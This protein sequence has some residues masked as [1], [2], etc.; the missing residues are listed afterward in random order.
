[1]THQALT[2]SRDR[3]RYERS[4]LPRKD[5]A[6]HCKTQ[7]GFTV[8]ELIVAMAIAAIM[9]GVALPAFMSFVAQQRLTADANAFAG[10]VAFARSES[11]RR[12]ALVSVQALGGGT[13]EWGGGYCVVPGNPGDCAGA[14]RRFDAP[15]RAS[16]DGTGALDGVT[17]LSF[18]GRGLLT[19]GQTGVLQLCS[20]D[21]L[22]DPGRQ[23]DISMIGRVSTSELE[24]PDP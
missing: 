11:T 10:A 18:N 4:D 22:E 20:D 5:R 17:T 12:G 24:C 6:A 16:F 19:L 14:L 9:M 3:C 15:V 7:G 1:M 2:A 8:V 23:I 21:S 13:G